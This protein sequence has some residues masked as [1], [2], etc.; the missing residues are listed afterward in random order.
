MEKAFR[1]HPGDNVAVALEAIHCGD[2]VLGVTAMDDIPSGHKLAIEEIKKDQP[3]I[4]YG[5]PIGT[6]Q[7]NILPGHWVHSHNMM[8]NLKGQISYTYEP[9]G[10]AVTPIFPMSFE[11]FRRKDGRI[12]IRNE[13]W[14]VPLV[15]C[16]NDICKELENMAAPLVEEFSLDGVYHFPHPYGCSQLGSDLDNTRR[17]LAQLCRHPNAGGVLVVSLGCENNT[18]EGFR[19]E[20]G[21]DYNDK[22]RYITCQNVDDELEIGFS[23][24]RELAEYASSFRR[25]TCSVS[26]LVIGM[27]CGGSDGLSGITAN[28]VVGRLS[29][30]LVAMGGTTILTEVPEMFGAETVL[31]NRCE[32]ISLFEKAASMVNDFKDYFISNGQPVDE[33]PSP[34]NKEGGIT[35]LE[36]KSLGCV[37]KG[38]NAPVSGVLNYGERVM[39]K[40]LNLLC[41]PGNDLVSSTALTAAGAQMILFTTGRGTPF[42][43]PAPTVK[44]STNSALYS[45]KPNWID[46][47]AGSVAEGEGVDSV[48]ER[49]LTYVLDVAN[50][51]YTCSERNHQYGIAIWK[52]GVTL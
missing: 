47:D 13:L 6:A 44:I 27:K 40:G 29:D 15:G 43:S 14:I 49:L 30:M 19:E 16:V 28:P 24:L 11:G 39:N 33:N 51:K 46:I 10:K 31:L 1:I 52:N 8:T 3:V 7:K 5:Y 18:L 48:A 45:S 20:L 26:E 37:Q 25:E 38:G 17:I 32:S 42:S 22:I 23:L 12:G 21:T 4:K 35:T 41:S 9:N 34:G 2:A 50:G 36:D